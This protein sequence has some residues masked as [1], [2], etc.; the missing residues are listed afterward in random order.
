[1]VDVTFNGQPL[2]VQFREILVVPEGV[3]SA[4][5]RAD[6][7]ASTGAAGVGFS[8]ANSYAAGSVGAHLK[9]FPSVKDAPY[10]AAGDGATNDGPSLGIAIAAASSLDFSTGT[11]ANLNTAVVVPF[12]NVAKFQM[13]A[14][15]TNSGTGTTSFAGVAIREGY[16]PG[17]L[18]GWTHTTAPYSHEGLSVEI[19]DYGPRQFG[20]FGTPTAL[21]GSINIPSTATIANH[22]NGVS[23]YVKNASTTTGGVAVYGE[24]NRTA[25]NALV[26][27]LNTRTRDNGFAGTL[28]GYEMD[29]NIDNV[30][31]T[32]IGF[33]A[34]GGSTVEPSLSVAYQVQAIGIFTSPKKRW[35]YGFR[36]R[37]AGAIIGLE[38]GAV[39]DSASS[40][41]QA[42]QLLYRNG[43]NTSTTGLVAQVSG[44]G[45]TSIVAGSAATLFVL[46]TSGASGNNI[47]M[48]ANALGFYGASPANQ[49]TTASA[50]ATFVTNAGTAVNDASTFDGYTI[51][52]VVKGLRT[53]GLLA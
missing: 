32:A 33:D 21:N 35:Q 53:I 30:G 48:L 50:S 27:G 22:A 8:H 23:G 3:P 16:N 10:S 49:T 19:G 5:L 15:I 12:G 44:T 46:K 24:A 38:L 28:W 26:W 40:G 7:L 31:T 29:M 51:K 13:G 4:L 37:D 9:L 18:M 20:S 11:Y 36:S 47:A 43:S 25:T 14:K 41:S 6:L 52:Q 42:L 45:D 17:S 2:V 34:V 1:M 39:M